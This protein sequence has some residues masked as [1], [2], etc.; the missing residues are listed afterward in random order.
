M[1]TSTKI[2][3]GVAALATIGV[4]GFLAYRHFKKKNESAEIPQDNTFTPTQTYTPTETPTSAEPSSSAAP[5][6]SASKPTAASSGSGESKKISAYATNTAKVDYSYNQGA[7]TITISLATASGKQT[8]TY[9]LS[10]VAAVQ[11]YIVE[12]MPES[13]A[14]M[15]NN[16]S[17]KADDGILGATTAKWFVA[18]VVKGMQSPTIMPQLVTQMAK[19]GVSVA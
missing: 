16:K 13:E 14:E 2:I 3:I 1:K 17:K 12:A 10:N 4:G 19:L 6:Q 15:K 7:K 8:K 9:K 5:T 18:L 11:R